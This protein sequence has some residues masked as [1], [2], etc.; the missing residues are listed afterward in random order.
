MWWRLVG[1]AIEY[2]ASLAGEQ[3]EF[4]KL[5]LKQEEDDEDSTSLADVLEILVKKW[6]EKFTAS[7]L[8]MWLDTCTPNDGEADIRYEPFWWRTLRQST[9]CRRKPSAGC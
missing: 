9:H 7:G 1:S 2:A 6:P 5:F 3:I 4:Q 8:K